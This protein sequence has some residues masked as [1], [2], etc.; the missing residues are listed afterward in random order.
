MQTIDGEKKKILLL[1][2]SISDY[3]VPIYN[4]I[5]KKYDLTVAYDI[6]DGS[7]HECYFKKLKLK[8]Y[9]ISS[10][11]LHTL[12]FYTLCKQ[13]DAV[14]IAPDMHYLMY[15]SLPFVSHKYKLLTWSIG[16]RASYTRKYDLHRKQTFLDKVFYSINAQ[17]DAII[18]YMREAIDFYR[19]NGINT[20]KVFIAHNTVEV[21]PIDKNQMKNKN[22]VLFVG[23]LYKE[24]NV[25]ELINAYIEV[26]QTGN[27]NIPTLIIVGDGAEYQNIKNIVDTNQLSKH[28]HLLG[29]I[30]DE[31]ILRDL[32]SE[33]LIC[34]S[35]NQAGLSV[36]KSL[37][38]GVPF[39]TRRNAITGGEILNIQ[40]GINGILYDKYEDLV[41]IINDVIIHKDKYL[42]MGKNAYVYYQKNATP[43]IMANGVIDALDYVFNDNHK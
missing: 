37:G 28:I 13:Y 35:P 5:N 40:D 12:S 8:S 6:K 38:Y 10:L 22:S 18:F 4:L 23:T 42:E 2:N 15:V 9:K 16:I 27:E 3:R 30:T 41:D 17:C 39:V 19:S 14:I 25:Y 20:D 31:N 11:T 33:A 1:Q 36:L 29:R 43:E 21:L 24:K 32:F 26:L 7:K 34:V